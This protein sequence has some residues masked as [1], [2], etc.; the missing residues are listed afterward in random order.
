MT[1]MP[2]GFLQE[3]VLN[4]WAAASP[5]SWNIPDI[6][7]QPPHSTELIEPWAGKAM[8]HSGIITSGGKG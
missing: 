5:A 1:V 3:A 4:K 7:V 8:E 2:A 6:V